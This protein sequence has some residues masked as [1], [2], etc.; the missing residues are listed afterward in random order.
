MLYHS[1]AEIFDGIDRSRARL[2]HRVEAMSDAQQSFRANDSAWSITE[3]LEHLSIL[4]TRMCALTIKLLQQAEA[5][6]ARASGLQI[7]PVSLEPYA[8][9]AAVEKYQA[10]EAVR[11]NGAIPVADSLAKM[12]QTRETLRALQPRLEA[13]DLSNAMFPHPVFGALDLYKWLA[14]IGLHEE[15]HLRQIEAI[16]A[17]PE[18]KAIG[19]TRAADAAV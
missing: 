4:E 13:A 16:T 2:R 11:P 14:F 5:S 9:R 1:I 3:I 18:F 15:R 19:D 10:P 17:T 8:A 7:A 6:G 12:Q